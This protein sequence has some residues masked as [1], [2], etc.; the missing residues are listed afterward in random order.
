MSVVDATNTLI[1]EGFEVSSEYKY[2]SSDTVKEGNVVKTMPDIGTKRKA[3]TEI[4]LYLASGNYLMEDFIGDNYLEVKGKIE[5]ACNCNV[6]VETE[7]VEEG[8]N[9]K[10]DA[11]L[12]TEPEAGKS[13]KLGETIKIISPEIEYKYPD[14]TD[15][16]TVEKVEEFAEKHELK[17]EVRYEESTTLEEGTIIKQN[18][19]VDSVVTPGAS[20]VITVTIPPQLDDEPVDDE[21]TIDDGNVDEVE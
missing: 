13:S 12:R 14:F 20:L 16:Y 11:V 21:T 4:I 5:A 18:R 7:K 10:E 19:A 15:G 17:L 2:V 9:V 6:V 8:K 1:D 3:G